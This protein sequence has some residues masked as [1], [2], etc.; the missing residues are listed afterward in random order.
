MHCVVCRRFIGIMDKKMD[1][2]RSTPNNPQGLLESKE[3]AA[4]AAGLPLTL[5]WHGENEKE[6]EK[7]LFYTRVYV[8]VI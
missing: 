5:Y 7:L 4:E 2:N 6:N 1:G 3:V 8:R